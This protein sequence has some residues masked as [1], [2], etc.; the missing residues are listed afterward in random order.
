[1][2]NIYLFTLSIFI[3]SFFLMSDHAKETPEVAFDFSQT[4]NTIEIDTLSTATPNV[5]RTVTV[6][7]PEAG[8]TVATA[9]ALFQFS[10]S[11]PDFPG[12]IAY[13]LT[14]NSTSF[15]STHQHNIFGRYV[16]NFHVFPV[17]IQRIDSCNDGQSVTYRFLAT[18][19]TFSFDASARQP[20]LV[21]VFY[22]DRI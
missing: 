10:V 18:R 2:N 6:V 16:D 12:T 15:Q 11:H 21:V 1:M 5:L 3:S 13:S 17:T 8:F 19:G 9:N 22:R 14:R 7:C 20:N 4:Y